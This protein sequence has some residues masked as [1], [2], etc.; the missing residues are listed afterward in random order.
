Y[1]IKL[2]ALM[3]TI[4]L[5]G[6]TA[7]QFPLGWLSDKLGRPGIYLSCGIIALLIGLALPLLMQT[8]TLLWPSLVILGAV[9]GGIYTLAIVLIGQS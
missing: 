4:I 1:S 2:A 7:F 3:V 5:L 8:T 6:D 9:A